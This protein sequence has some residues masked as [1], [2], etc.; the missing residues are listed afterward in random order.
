MATNPTL[1]QMP[2]VRDGDKSTI[3]TTDDGTTGNFSQQY[4]WQLINSLPLTSGGKAV[5]RQD[6]NGVLNLL[7]NILY[8]AQKGFTF[9]YDNTQNY[10]VGCLVIDSDDGLR[11][12]CIQDAPAGTGKP[13]TKPAYWRQYQLP[14]GG[15][16]TPVGTVIAFAG[17]TIPAHYLLCDGSAVSRTTYSELFSVIGLIYGVGNGTTTFNLPNL[18]DRV[19]QGSGT[20]GTYRSAGLPNIRGGWS[21]HV[22]YQKP[23]SG[24]N[25]FYYSGTAGRATQD[26]GYTGYD[27]I[28][29]DASR[30]NAIYGASNTVQPPALTMKYCIKYE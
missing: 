18:T 1:L 9:N 29:F 16:T 28:Y 4:G 14:S 5:L 27:Y 11:Y 17:N 23:V 10:Y 24:P 3:P 22:G 15:D 12:E 7:S 6:L 8:Y 19:I 25:A 2:L 30:F 20:V 26:E 21:D 13:H